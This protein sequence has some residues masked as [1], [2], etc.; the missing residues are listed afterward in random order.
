[1]IRLAFE[2]WRG[3][4]VY[5]DI[6]AQRAMLADVARI[7][8]RHMQA[9]M[10]GPHTGRT[11][12]LRNGQRHTASV[13]QTRR[14]YPAVRTGSLLRSIGTETNATEAKIGTR[15]SYARYLRT[16]TIKMKRRRMSDT[17]LHFGAKAAWGRKRP[18][19][20]FKHV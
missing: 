18:F 3:L 19:A 17:A 10:K 8:R 20:R 9:G 4:T 7:G 15:K 12:T 11:Y 16:G 14:E 2:P 5:R 6:D 1:M 13:D